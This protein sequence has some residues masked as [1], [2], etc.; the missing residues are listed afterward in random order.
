MTCNNYCFS[1][2]TM[3]A[4]T[5]LNATLHVHFLSCYMY[6]KLLSKFFQYFW[7]LFSYTTPLALDFSFYK[8]FGNIFLMTHKI[9]GKIAAKEGGL[10]KS[11]H[12]SHTLS[13]F[14]LFLL[15]AIERPCDVPAPLRGES[16]CRLP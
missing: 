6:N 11:P 16:V 7:I 3:V 4:R 14:S 12:F 10:F 2:V 1:I 13:T 15:S 5:C 9:F 8:T